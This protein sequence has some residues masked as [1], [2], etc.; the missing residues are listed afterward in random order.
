[1]DERAHGLSSWS[2]GLLGAIAVSS[3]VLGGALYVAPAWAAPRFAWSVSPLVA[4]TIGGWFLGNAFWAS[5]IVRD[6][7][8]GVH[9]SGLVYLWCF[10]AFQ[11]VVVVAYRDRVATDSWVAL[12]YLATIAARLVAAV[13]G[14][15]D[16]RRL[17]PLAADT[18][19]QAPGWLRALAVFFVLFVSFLTLVGLFF[20]QAAVGG[21]V[22][23]EDMSPF[24]VRS[25]GVYFL[26]LTVAA[27][28]VTRRRR[29]DLML[30][31]IA[32]GLAITTTVLLAA[33]VHLEVFDVA[34][35]PLQWIYLGSYVA[36]IAVAGPTLVVFS[37]RPAEPPADMP[38]KHTR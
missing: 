20:P 1:M 17:R 35:H 5:R 38:A 10:G 37:R 7:R 21:A 9:A 36:V 32:G 16:L 22:F 29:M 34:R 24:T 12:L 28:V 11:S 33:L 6:W 27:L 2:R 26:A 25:F 31:H 8:W 30:A 23:P 3:A 13:L 4:M 19:V 14:V 18:G 15:A